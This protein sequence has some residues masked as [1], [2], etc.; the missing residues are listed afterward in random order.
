M[1]Y[2]IPLNILFH[3][4]MIESSTFLFPLSIFKYF[5]PS[6]FPTKQNTLLITK[7]NGFT[8]LT[9]RSSGL[10]CQHNII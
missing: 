9:H 6:F 5:I 8:L 4:D 1:F 2:F 10:F 7:Y 3:I